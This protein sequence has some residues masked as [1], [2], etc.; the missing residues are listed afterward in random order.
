MNPR[1]LVAVYGEQQVHIL[2]ELF[3]YRIRVPLD[4]MSAIHI[5]EEQEKRF[6]ILVLDASR[7]ESYE[8]AEYAKDLGWMAK[9][10]FVSKMDGLGLR[11]KASQIRCDAFF[12][13][14]EDLRRFKPLVSAIAEDL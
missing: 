10:I 6:D 11:L 14:P 1:I 5:S 7:D 4:V 8:A 3:G 9:V 12:I 2:K 13:L